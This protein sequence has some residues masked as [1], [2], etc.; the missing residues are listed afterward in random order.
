MIV[1]ELI[2]YQNIFR[3]PYLRSLFGKNNDDSTDSDISRLTDIED[4]FDSS[5]FETGDLMAYHDR[6]RLE[7][8]EL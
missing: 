3:V 2:L 8:T 7:E 4:L 1:F 6:V 5:L